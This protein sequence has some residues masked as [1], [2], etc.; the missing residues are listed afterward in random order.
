MARKAWSLTGGFLYRNCKIREDTGGGWENTGNFSEIAIFPLVEHGFDRVP[1][2]VYPVLSPV[3]PVPHR[4]SEVGAGGG[5]PFGWP[6][7]GRG[8]GKWGMGLRGVAWSAW[9]CGVTGGTSF[10]YF[11]NCSPVCS[12]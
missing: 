11:P 1:S 5:G 4:V 2:P 7:V 10:P 12:P 3:A 6:Q 8:G 9:A